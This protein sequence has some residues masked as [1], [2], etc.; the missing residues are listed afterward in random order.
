MKTHL[1]KK[2]ASLLLA[3]VGM[4][5]YIRIRFREWKFGAAA[6]LGVLHDVLVMIAFYAVFRVTVNNPFI[7]AILTVVGYSI[8]DTIVIFDRVRENARLRHSGSTEQLLDDSINQTL[9]RSVMTSLTTLVVMIPLLVMAGDAIREF[10]LPLMVGVITGCY[11]SI[12]ICSPLYYV[13]TRKE[14]QSRYEKQIASKGKKSGKKYVGAV[15][16]K[17]PKETAEEPAETGKNGEKIVGAIPADMRDDFEEITGEKQEILAS[18]PQDVAEEFD[19][20]SEEDL[21]EEAEISDAID[22][23]ILEAAEQAVMGKKKGYHVSSA[24]AHKKTRKVK[25]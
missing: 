2:G 21:L 8:N 4:L 15:S 16:T 5:I 3:A 7:A 13:M 12:F 17:K 22:E 6:I 25:R 19:K 10:T 9:S 20:I 24:K 14:R 18:V 1:F 11:S 23:D